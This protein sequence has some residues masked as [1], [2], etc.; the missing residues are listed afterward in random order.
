MDFI[1]ALFV[2]ALK[3]RPEQCLSSLRPDVWKLYPPLS[4]L[5]PHIVPH[6][7]L[8]TNSIHE[9]PTN[10]S[11]LPCF[12]WCTIRCYWCFS[13]GGIKSRRLIFIFGSVD[14]FEIVAARKKTACGL[15]PVQTYNFAIRP[16]PTFPFKDLKRRPW[17][18][19][20]VNISCG[21]SGAFT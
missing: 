18:S 10:K 16:R 5:L 6:S 19:Q 3:M 13:H 17:S 15:I 20:A 21:L 1:A 11:A 2:G 7:S 14:H 8:H 4:S 12:T 9:K